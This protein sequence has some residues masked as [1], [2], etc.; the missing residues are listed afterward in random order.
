MVILSPHDRAID[1]AVRTGVRVDDPYGYTR[2]FS[3]LPSVG[4]RTWVRD[5]V[6]RVTDALPVVLDPTAGGGSIPFESVRLGLP[7]LV[8]DINPVAALLLRAT[9]EWPAHLGRAVLEEFK[10]LSAAWREALEK[11]LSPL[12]PPARDAIT[13]DI[14][15]LWARTVT[16]P[17]CDGLI[18]LSPNWRLAPDGTGVR[19]HPDTATRRCTFEIVPSAKLQSE[20]TV[21]GGDAR[22]PWPACGRIVDGDEVKRQALAGQMGEQLYAVV[23]KRKVV[24]KTKTGKERIKWERGYRAPRPEDD[25]SAFI[26]QQLADKLPEWEANGIVPT[27]RFPEDGN[28]LRPIIYG[29][30]LWRDLFGPRQLSPTATEPR[31]TRSSSQLV[32][33]PNRRRRPCICR[34]ASTRC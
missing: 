13:V 34:S 4:E 14:T 26:Q 16:C 10:K 15:Y 1:E 18:P 19:L 11:R 8:N 25:N 5:E 12:F 32:R 24:T 3:Y 27:E 23:F 29:M 20:G 7:T 2:A 21:T 6:A 33:R 22:C 17:Y 9:V 30:P 31:S 28:D